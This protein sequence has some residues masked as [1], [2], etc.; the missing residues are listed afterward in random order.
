[1]IAGW[2][3]TQNVAITGRQGV[4]GALGINLRAAADTGAA[5]VGLVKEGAQVQI[6]GPARNIY[7]PIWARRE[8]ILDLASPLPAIAPPDPFPAGSPPAAAPAPTIS[9]PAMS[10]HAGDDRATPPSPGVRPEPA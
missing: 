1:M 4:I 10:H 9:R 3:F 2:A 8:D 5:K 6:T 7:T